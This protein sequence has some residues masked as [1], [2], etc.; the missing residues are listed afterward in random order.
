MS[1][2]PIKQDRAH[3]TRARIVSGAASSFAE[4]GYSGS[5]ISDILQRSEVT[6]GAL[7]FHFETKEDVAQAVLDAHATW[8][9]AT[10]NAVRGRCLQGLLD[11]SYLFCDALASDD[12][13]R[14]AA[15]LSVDREM[16][17]LAREP[18]FWQ[19]ER[20]AVG[21]LDDAQGCGELING[22]DV[23]AVA[24]VSMSMLLGS[25]LA[26]LVADGGRGGVHAEMSRYWALVLPGFA[27]PDVRA[28]LVLAE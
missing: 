24:R 22:V 16:F 15:R 27:D 3:E 18:I 5:T 2:Q 11:L 23:K 25:H 8:L 19:W 26:S 4:N 28:G 6:K 12:V 21:L 14:A 20:L 17:D 7:Y 1:R 10:A 9:E 13:L